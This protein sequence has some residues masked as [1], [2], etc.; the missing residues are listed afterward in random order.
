MGGQAMACEPLQITANALIPPWTAAQLKA[1][2]G[3]YSLELMPIYSNVGYNFPFVV[4]QGMY[5]GITSAGFASKRIAKQSGFSTNYFSLYGMFTV[6]DQEHVRTFPGQPFL[7]PPGATITGSVANAS[8]K[9]SMN[10]NV[11]VTGW[12]SG[13]PLFRDCR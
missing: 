8:N 3:H 9:S 6:T 5:A 4:P 12:L 7:V 13:D 2:N 10:M 11:Y 1:T